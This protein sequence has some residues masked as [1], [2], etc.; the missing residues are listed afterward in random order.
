MSHARRLSLLFVALLLTLNHAAFAQDHHT[1][2]AAPPAY[3][4]A[5]LLARELPLRTGIGNSSEAITT[6]SKDAQ[7]YYTQG[8]NYLESYVWIEAARSFNQALRLDPTCAMANLGLSYVYSGLESSAGAKE[9]YERAKAL[10]GN[11]SERERMRIEIRGKQLHAIDDIKDSARFMAYKKAVDEALA[12]HVDDPV[13]W[14]LR[15]NAEEPN[16]SGRGQ[17]GGASSAAF[18]HSVLAIQPDHATAHHYL[19]HS[20][21]TIGRI[22]KALEHGDDYARLT[23]SIPHSAHMWGHDLRRVGKVDEAIEQFKRTDQ[24]ERAYYA[25]EKMDPSMD[26]HHAHNLD[27]LASCYQHKGQLKQAEQTLRESAKLDVLSAYRAFNQRE[28]PNFLLQRARYED[29]LKEARALRDS[30]Y[31]QGRTVGHALAGQALLALGRA[32][33][34][35]AELDAAAKELENVPVMGITLDPT[36]SMV[37]PWVDALRGEMLLRSGKQNEGVEILK[38][39]IKGL[40]SS[41]GPDAWSQG[42]FRLEQMAH[43]AIETGAWEFADYV[44]AQMVEHDRAYAGSHYVTA[45]V[46]QHKGDAAGALREIE[47]AK[48]YWKDADADLPELKTMSEVAVQLNGKKKG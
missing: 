25:A 27:L 3:V 20:Y 4:P 23:T 13:F 34:A 26:W 9:F 22:D 15:G 28:Y 48:G 16:A 12:K 5:E 45:L 10:S 44:A 46:L 33:E 24:L 7:A 2:C 17:R 43:T 36:Q 1:A 32:D 47:T 29:A 6:K 39:V 31:V 35:K 40:R 42:L 19:V 18:Y 14:V 11:V 37:A 41:P 21:E 8:L 30:K 38:G